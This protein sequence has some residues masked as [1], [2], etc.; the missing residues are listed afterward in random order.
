VETLHQLGYKARFYRGDAKR[1][2]TK[3]LSELADS[4]LISVII[5]DELCAE[6]HNSS[7]AGYIFMLSN[8]PNTCSLNDFERMNSA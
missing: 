7:Y 3:A 8:L 1:Q 2:L 4:G 5:V 6:Q